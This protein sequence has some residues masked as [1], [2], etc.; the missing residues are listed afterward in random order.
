[1]APDFSKS[2]IETLAK[3]AAYICSNPDCR[4]HTIGPNTEADKAT[5]VGEAAH[6]SGARPGSRRYEPN[7]NDI[8]RSEITNAIWLCRNCHKM[9]D[10]DEKK[11]SSSILFQWRE[12]HEAFITSKLGNK[13]EQIH[14]EEQASLLSEFDGYP[15]IVKRII[16]DM[17]TCWEYRLSAELMRFFNAPLF[18]KLEDLNSG[19]YMKN[20][21]IIPTDQEWEWV[22]EKFAAMA[23][24]TNTANTLLEK[25]MA[26]WGVPGEVGEVNEIH[27]ATK[28]IKEYLE[29]VVVYEEQIR[30]SKVSEKFEHILTLLR[31]VMSSQ[32]LKLS[33]IPDDLDQFVKRC[34]EN[35]RNGTVSSK[36]TT[37]VYVFKVPEGWKQEVYN[38]IQKLRP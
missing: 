6:I 28:L 20:R 11:Y 34:I 31:G 30:F 22:E 14:F 24:I 8:A 23:E 5:T 36:E 2:T 4:V 10:T 3:R 38:E 13:T 7:L 18:R 9:I 29:Q 19:L 33:S 35:D 17:P 21:K 27:H 32:V 16:T 25:L 12:I 15:P 26:S 1:M 37:H